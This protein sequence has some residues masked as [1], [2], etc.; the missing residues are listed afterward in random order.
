MP[1][2]SHLAPARGQPSYRGHDVVTVAERADLVGATD[3]DLL[4]SAG[5]EGRALVTNNASHLLPIATELLG[6]SGGSHGGLAH[7]DERFEDGFAD[8]LYLEI[9]AEDELPL[10]TVERGRVAAS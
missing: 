4:E 9:M 6:S 3:R 1:A 2:D 10:P 7:Q 8:R 5:D